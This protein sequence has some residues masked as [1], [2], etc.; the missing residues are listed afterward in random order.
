MGMPLMG[1][2]SGDTPDKAQKFYLYLQGHQETMQRAATRLGPWL[3]GSEAGLFTE[4]RAAA[5]AERVAAV[6]RIVRDSP[7]DLAALLE[8]EPTPP[9]KRQ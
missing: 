5:A 2:P 6:Q 8:L 1:I 7:P 9:R 3:T 4:A